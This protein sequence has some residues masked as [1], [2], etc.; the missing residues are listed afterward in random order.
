MNIRVEEND[1]RARQ[2]LEVTCWRNIKWFLVLE[3]MYR[4]FEEREIGNDHNVED[5]S[6]ER[7]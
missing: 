4:M 5:L 1:M 6:R 2:H 7:T 3:N